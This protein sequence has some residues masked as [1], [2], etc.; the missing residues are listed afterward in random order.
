MGGQVW[1][2]RILGEFGDKRALLA[3]FEMLTDTDSDVRRAAVDA[4]GETW[5]PENAESLMTCT[6]DS[7]RDVVTRAW[8]AL[9]RLGDPRAFNPLVILLLAPDASKQ[10]I[11]AAKYSCDWKHRPSGRAAF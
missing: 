11:S 10:D 6:K 1:R 4:L 3:F 5:R 8:I 9:G 7:D 2:R